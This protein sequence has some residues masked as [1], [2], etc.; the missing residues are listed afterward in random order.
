[1]AEADSTE[2]QI[3]G[4]LRTIEEKHGASHESRHRRAVAI[5]VW[6][7][8]KSAEVRDRALQLL[9][10]AGELATSSKVPLSEWLTE[11]L[12]REPKRDS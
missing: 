5:A 11:R 3:A 7:I 6:H 4:Y 12:M 9:R 1:M 8:A 10:E 2:V